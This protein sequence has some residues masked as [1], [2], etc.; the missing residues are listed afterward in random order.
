MLIGGRFKPLLVHA[1]VVFQFGQ[2]GADKLFVLSHDQPGRG[3]L[4]EWR[5]RMSSHIPRASRAD[6]AFRL[7]DTDDF[8]I[9][10]D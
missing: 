5:T 6:K 1:V 4:N 9:V 3:A 7:L 8:G 2:Q 10:G